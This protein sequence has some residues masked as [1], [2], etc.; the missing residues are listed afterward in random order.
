MLTAKSTLRL[1]DLVVYEEYLS[2][3]YIVELIKNYSFLEAVIHWQFKCQDNVSD[4]SI[5]AIPCCGIKLKRNER[6][7][8]QG[9]KIICAG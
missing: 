5:W 2:S 7:V 3:Q 6:I 1:Q 8:E 9:K 4:L